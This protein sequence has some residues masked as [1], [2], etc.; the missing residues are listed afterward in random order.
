QK[1]GLQFQFG[2][3]AQLNFSSL[4]AASTGAVFV[5]EALPIPVFQ[6]SFLTGTMTPRKLAAISIFT[7]DIFNHSL[8]SIELTVRTVLGDDIATGR[9]D[10]RGGCRQCADQRLR[11]NSAIQLC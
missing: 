10:G 1:I 11:S 6:Q 4:L 2:G 8:P 9:R 7:L 5:G 3:D